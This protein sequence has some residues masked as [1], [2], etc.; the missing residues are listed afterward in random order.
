MCI[1]DSAFRF[2]LLGVPI[3][4]VFGCSFLI[5]LDGVEPV[6]Y[7]HLHPAFLADTEHSAL[8]RMIGKLLGIHAQA[9]GIIG[10]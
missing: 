6:S 3:L 1:R 5:R 2:N 8:C 4:L 9:L 7:T 10:I